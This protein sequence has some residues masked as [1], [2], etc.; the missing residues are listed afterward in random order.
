LCAG[1]DGVSGGKGEDGGVEGEDGGVVSCSRTAAGCWRGQEFSI[2]LDDA[3]FISS[4]MFGNVLS[5]E[6]S[7]LFNEGRV[8][9]IEAREE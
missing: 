8:R 2:F 5:K 6:V 4:A 3:R 1:G 7:L 9:Q